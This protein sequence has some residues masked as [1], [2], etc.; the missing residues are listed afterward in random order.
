MQ[1]L[2]RVLSGMKSSGKSRSISLILPRL[3]LIQGFPGSDPGL[4][5]YAASLSE[6]NFLK[7][8]PLAGVFFTAPIKI[9]SFLSSGHNF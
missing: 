9:R 1:A 3:Q 5:F 6:A 8:L 7:D 4:L 2:F